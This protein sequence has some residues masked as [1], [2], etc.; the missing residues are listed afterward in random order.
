MMIKVFFE[1]FA[2]TENTPT[3]QVFFYDDARYT[4]Q[5]II[6]K[7]KIQRIEIIRENDKP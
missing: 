7:E 5:E 2:S 3:R 1:D 6:E 4:L